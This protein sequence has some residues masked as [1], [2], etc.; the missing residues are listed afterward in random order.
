MNRTRP[1]TGYTA[2]QLIERLTAARGRL[3]A[4]ID[5]LP[6]NGWLGP[7]AD[8]LNPP[9][10]EYG[11]IVWFQE[12]WCLRERPDGSCQPGLLPGA[13]ALYD[14]SHVP[15]DTRWD[16]PLLQPDQVDDYASRVAVA[17][18]DRLHD[19]FD[20]DIA[21]FAE[22]SLYHELMHVEAWW[23]AFQNL[24]YA[25]PEQPRVA[26]TALPRRLTV[27]AGEVELGS[28]ADAG[29][30]FDNEKWR[31]VIP[32]AGF[33]IDTSPVSETAFA[34]FV[35]RGGYLH[36]ALWS[37]AGWAWRVAGDVRH[38]LYWRL[39]KDGWQARRFDRWLPLRADTPVLHV[40]RHEAEA[41]AAW[42]GRRLPAAVQW[43]QATTET[44]FEWGGAW[45]WLRDAFA[46]YPGFTP[47]PYR[48]Y[49]QPWFH[50]HWELRG[51]GPVT[52]AS[53]KYPGFRNFYRP[54]RR[55]P[56]AGFRTVSAD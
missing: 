31:H 43:K 3:R 30:V 24:G 21:Y 20:D 9:L 37:E 2:G 25:P 38:P 36:R 50:T 49:S 22:L 52:D 56:F 46:P 35:E 32:F 27:A 45:E 5:A 10:W 8:H 17:V 11:H 12:R 4:L 29:F 1:V 6:A 13:D 47:D 51:G 7:R 23:M 15:H 55:D 54:D 26:A 42:L 16:L 39:E 34:E 19:R 44:A 48:D 41:C 33:D 14:S 53:L 40:N 18:A 28:D